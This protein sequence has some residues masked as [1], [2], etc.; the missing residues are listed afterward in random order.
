MIAL[1]V[2]F[3]YKIEASVI[4]T[5]WTRKKYKKVHALTSGVAVPASSSRPHSS[6]D[7][8]HY[9]RT[10]PSSKQIKKQASMLKA[11]GKFLWSRPSGGEA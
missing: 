9:Y 2:L 6:G 3:N 5:Y 8:H 1:H 4:C 7:K 11:P 10:L